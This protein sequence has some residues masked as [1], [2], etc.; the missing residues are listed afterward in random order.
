VADGG[1]VVRAGPAVAAEGPL[2]PTWDVVHSP[3]CLFF[4][5]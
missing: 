4:P 2:T 1:S 3:P 5:P